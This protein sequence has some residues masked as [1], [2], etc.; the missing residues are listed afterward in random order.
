LSFW[1]AH[2]RFSVFGTAGS[3]TASTGY[4]V[5][6][7]SSNVTAGGLTA[8]PATPSVTIAAPTAAL[9]DVVLL[10]DTVTPLLSGAA[11]RDL[12]LYSRHDTTGKVAATLL[13]GRA[14][15]LTQDASDASPYPLPDLVRALPPGITLRI[16]GD[17][18]L[19]GC[20]RLR[21]L[22]LGLDQNHTARAGRQ[23]A[24]FFLSQITRTRSGK[25]DTSR[26]SR[27][28]TA[29]HPAGTSKSGAFQRERSS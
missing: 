10:G 20:R 13:T 18:T 1:L 7:P 25:P 9:P 15:I 24:V 26:G 8:L 3:V 12:A 16:V 29:S 22:K 11:A 23:C 5:F 27:K 17:H 21:P 4:V 28:T 6:A 14:G 19:K 2:S